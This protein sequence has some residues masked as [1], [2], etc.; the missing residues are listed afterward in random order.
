MQTIMIAV[1]QE[2]PCRP[3]AFGRMIQ[4]VLDLLLETVSKT[5]VGAPQRIPADQAAAE[6]DGRAANV[7]TVRETNAEATHVLQPGIRALDDATVF[8][9]VAA[10]ASTA[11]D[12]HRL[13]I[14]ITQRSWMSH[15]VVSAIGVNDARPPQRM[16][17][18]AA[19][20][21]NRVE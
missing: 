5:L 12:N 16:A 17:A 1:S 6:F 18:Q 4:P 20:W 2:F 19:N 21:R 7:G 15:G 3:A 8:A 10:T 13:D 11:R 9:K 14:A